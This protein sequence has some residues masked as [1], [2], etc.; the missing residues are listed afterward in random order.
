MFQVLYEHPSSWPETGSLHV[1]LPPVS[2]EV[3]ISPD[4]A[5]RHANGYLVTYV[6]MTLHAINPV[7]VIGEKPIWRLSLE[8]RL[9]DLGPPAILGS[10]DVDAQTGEA[11][12]L[13]RQQIEAIQ[14]QVD[15]MIARYR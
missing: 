6:S 5:R 11:I 7:L 8:M 10:L 14:D 9:L 12:P 2:V 15:E 4:T 3:P 1:E 13:S